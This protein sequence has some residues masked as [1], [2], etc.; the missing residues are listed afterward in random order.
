[1]I[2]E[3]FAAETVAP[4][5]L[6]EAAA[7]MRDSARN[8]TT[9]AFAGGGTEFGYGRAPDHVGMLL[10]TEKLD[11]VVDY[12]PADMTITVEAG[13]TLA[14]LQQTL[15]VNSQ[16]LALDAPQPERATLGG[17]LAANTYGPL[18][19]RYGTLRDLIVGVEMIRADGSRARG[20]G[21]VV[22]NVAGF[23]IAKLLVGSLGTLA[24]ITEVAFRLHPVPPASRTVLFESRSAGD[25]CE[26]AIR[27]GRLQVTPSVVDLHW[28]RG[29]VVARFDSS[30]QGAVV[31]AERV[32]Q[33]CGGRILAADE[34]AALTAALRGEPW[35]GSGAVGAIAVLP[36]RIS[37]FLSS[38]SATCGAIA[39]RPLLGIGEV[40]FPPEAMEMVRAAVRTS[41]GRLMV[42]RGDTP[43]AGEPDDAVALDLMRS[44]KQ[45]L[46]PARTL[47]PGRQV[48]GI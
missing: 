30:E 37:Q 27:V 23:D 36:S 3:A 39:L 2:A 13:V 15:A 14:A 18:R 45:Q 20:G 16:R 12:A 9:V 35:T 11:K 26:F 38:M 43:S 33:D 10:K 1:M 8:K 7:A 4:K 24:V 34:E 31:Q 41:G 25:L 48:G 22:K 40:R 28:P 47:S 42:R 21:K 19:T 44:V 46:D 5:T 29:M 32:V 17:L 6:D